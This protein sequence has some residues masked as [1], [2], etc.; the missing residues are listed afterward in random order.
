MRKIDETETGIACKNP[1]SV[2]AWVLGSMHSPKI[3]RQHICVYAL[4]VLHDYSPHSQDTEAQPL[5]PYSNWNVLEGVT[6]SAG[7]QIEY[8]ASAEACTTDQ[9]DTDDASATFV[10]GETLEQKDCGNLGATKVVGVNMQVSVL[11][12]YLRSL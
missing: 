9:C 10:Q 5:P 12:N 3:N 7:N 8:S 6:V 1:A 4:N 11:M 2:K